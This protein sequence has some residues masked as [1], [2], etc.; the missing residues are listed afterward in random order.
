MESTDFAFVPYQVLFRS[1][2]IYENKIIYNL[3]LYSLYKIST[4]MIQFNIKILQETG[5]W[6]T[7]I[8]FLIYY[9]LL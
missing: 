8:V 9:I 7:M 5:N 2:I 3:R 1:M 6:V 4:N